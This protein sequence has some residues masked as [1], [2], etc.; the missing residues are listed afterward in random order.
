MSTFEDKISFFQ[1]H[2]SCDVFNP[3]T[4]LHIINLIGPSSS[5]E[6]I[7]YIIEESE[8]AVDI[9]I[10][11]SSDFVYMILDGNSFTA[12]IEHYWK[13]WGQ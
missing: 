11:G 13:C 8:Y 10:K 7:G 4:D 6:F 3:V 12:L 2:S 5:Q 9:S 1:D